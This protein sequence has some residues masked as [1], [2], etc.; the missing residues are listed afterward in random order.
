MIDWAKETPLIIAACAQH[1]IDEAF[2]RAIREQENGPD[3]TEGKEFGEFGV[4]TRLAASY[5]EQLDVTIHTVAH[6]LSDFQGNPL[7]LGAN[8][9]LIYS[10]TWLVRFAAI[11]A[12]VGANNDP[13][14]LNA[15]WPINV[16]K[17]YI[18]NV[19]EG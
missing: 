4:P 17:F 9:R 6:W 19:R 13:T 10:H 11:W 14:G 2:V 15:A 1:G 5:E 18:A 3:A 7:M 16:Q 12:P 8:H